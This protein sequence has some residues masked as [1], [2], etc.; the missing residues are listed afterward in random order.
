MLL[1]DPEKIEHVVI[2]YPNKEGEPANKPMDRV[3]FMLKEAN[4]DGRV[5]EDREEIEWT[6]S[7]TTGK[8]V[9]KWIMKGFFLLDI[10]REGNGKFD[11]KYTISPHL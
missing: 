5:P 2:T 6:T 4:Y 9:L 7:E 10:S 1:F 8:E 3:K 11:T